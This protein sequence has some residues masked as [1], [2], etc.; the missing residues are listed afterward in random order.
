MERIERIR[1]AGNNNNGPVGRYH[2]P[3]P[4]PPSITGDVVNELRHLIDQSDCYTVET[5]EL[6]YRLTVIANLLHGYVMNDEAR[7]SDLFAQLNETA[8]SDDQFAPKMAFVFASQQLGALSPLDQ[9]IRN[10]M[11]TKL[12]DNYG[13]KDRL[14]Q[15]GRHRFYNSI[16]LLGE[17]YHRKRDAHGKRFHILGEKLLALLTSELEQEIKQCGKQQQQQGQ[18]QSVY[19]TIDP[20]FA[21]VILSQITLNGEVAREELRQEI[22]ELMLMVRKCLLTVSNLCEWTKAFLLMALDFYHA[23]LPQDVFDRLYTKYLVEDPKPEP[24]PALAPVAV[25]TERPVPAH[26]AMDAP[27]YEPLS[28]EPAVG[29]LDDESVQGLH[30]HPQYLATNHNLSSLPPSPQPPPSPAQIV[31]AVPLEAPPK[32]RNAVSNKENKRRPPSRH[33]QARARHSSNQRKKLEEP[34]SGIVHTVTSPPTTPTSKKGTT[35]PPRTVTLGERSPPDGKKAMVS[36]PRAAEKLAN[37]PK[38]TVTTTNTGTQSRKPSTAA[39]PLSPRGVLVVSS[40]RQQPVVQPPKSPSS[41]AAR[42]SSAASATS[43][44]KASQQSDHYINNN[45]SSSNS[46]RRGGGGNDRRIPSKYI[47]PRFAAQQRK[48]QEA[49]AANANAHAASAAALGAPLRNGSSAPSTKGGSGGNVLKQQ[50]QQQQHQQQQQQYVKNTGTGPKANGQTGHHRPPRSPSKTKPADW[51]SHDDRRGPGSRSSRKQDLPKKTTTNGDGNGGHL[52]GK[53]ANHPQNPVVLDWAAEDD[54]YEPEARAVQEPRDSGADRTAYGQRKE[55]TIDWATEEDAK[56]VT[57]VAP[58]PTKPKVW[59]WAADD[60]DYYE[61]VT[62]NGGPSDNNVANNKSATPTK[63]KPSPQP[64]REPKKWDW[65]ADEDDEDE[66]V[67][68]YASAGNSNTVNLP[69]RDIGALSTAYNERLSL[70]DDRRSSQKPNPNAH[71]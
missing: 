10:A 29:H 12:Q 16:T 36:P 69:E 4:P 18:L 27:Y 17:Y 41:R 32:E 9:S 15:A 55:Q 39:A 44:T 61:P 42:N 19:S 30:A 24:E 56:P 62:V 35:V 71:A 6:G 48:E 57:N 60:D 47:I 64:I 3:T 2:Q 52:G 40:G 25:M 5:I 67:P 45:S 37:L 49:R 59:D 34:E 7:L 50:Q 46:G 31:A 22:T 26:V 54:Y 21:K 11:I 8:L 33:E 38:L 70:E 1:A 43:N 51:Y 65:A 14:K 63:L 20:A 58:A 68:Y 28:P 13:A 66:Y 23:N 53:S